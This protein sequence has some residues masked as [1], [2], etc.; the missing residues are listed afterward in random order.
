MTRYGLRCFLWGIMTGIVIFIG[1]L[2]AISYISGVKWQPVKIAM[3]ADQLYG[4]TYANSLPSG[5]CK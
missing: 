1:S 4:C 2:A 3:T 5:E